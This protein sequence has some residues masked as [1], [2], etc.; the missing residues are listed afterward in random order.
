MSVTFSPRVVGAHRPD[1]H[2]LESILASPQ[3]AGKTGEDLALA[4]YDYFTSRV[5]GTYH[6][7]P[8]GETEGNPRIRRSVYDPVKLLNAYGWAICGQTAH[9]LY[10][11]YRA[12]GLLPR[13]IGLPGHSL[14]EVHYDGRWHILDVD[15]WTWF[16][17][18]EGHIASAA[19]LAESPEELILH[20]AGRSNPCDLPDR[21]LEDY[22]KMYAKTKT[23]D[24]HVEGVCPPWGIRAHGMDFRLRPGETLIR[25]QENH[26]RFHMPQEWLQ[27]KAKYKREWNCH[28]RERY[29][30]FRTFG[31]GRWIYQPD[32]TDG[33]GD[34][35]AGLWE[36]SD[37]RQDAA[38]LLGPGSATWRIASPYPFCGVPDWKGETVSHCDGVWLTLAGRGPVRAELTDPEGRWV[39]VL[40]G[41]GEFD[42]RIDVTQLLSSR[43]GCLIRL[44]LGKRARL[45]RF[46]FEGFLMTAP[47]S[48]PRLAEG[49]NAVELRCCDKHGLCT[50][51]WAEL[52]DF[53]QGAELPA[54]W[55]EADNAEAGPYADGWQMI[56]PA[57]RGDVRVV[58]RFAAPAGGKF[59]WAY[60]HAG[61]REGPTDKPPGR[62]TLE[63]SDDGQSW[64]DLSEIE[65]SNTPRQWDCSIDGEVVFPAPVDAVYLRV[66]SQ[67]A[68]SG[69]EFHGHLAQG[70]SLDPGAP[71]L[72]VTHRWRE[73]G[74]ERSFS[75]SAGGATE[76]VIRCGAAPAAH[77]IEMHVPSIPRR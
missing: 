57:G 59:A 35:Q 24:G 49:D 37:V 70:A 41:E 39:K 6:F 11:L 73:G 14:C 27:F 19:E 17:S 61:L 20:S 51:P 33:T 1:F 40:S 28:P 53:R 3:F 32:L 60:A 64:H 65:I 38:G 8:S 50:V 54:Q 74:A 46:G 69:V 71:G 76:Y 26:G 23:V 36:A 15:M 2:C 16:R 25:S 58:F 72:Q 12:G 52:I 34:F 56:S 47:L 67:T 13:H 31:N 18:R 5:D 66:T 45:G 44:T 68:I 9:I 22:A 63:W 75:K 55:V 43:Y 29:E 62:A 48:V 4:I 7:W 10:G 42:R 77:T 21:K 30:P